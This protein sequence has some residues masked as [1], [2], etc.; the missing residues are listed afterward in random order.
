VRLVTSTLLNMFVVPALYFRFGA[1]PSAVD[2]KESHSIVKGGGESSPIIMDPITE[3]ARVKVNAWG[4]VSLIVLVGGY[5]VAWKCQLT[6]HVS[7]STCFQLC[8]VLEGI[9]LACGPFC[10]TTRPTC[11]GSPLQPRVVI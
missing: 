8:V 10:P 4:I 1:A 5:L 9:A 3:P 2:S 7:G 6:P 11:F